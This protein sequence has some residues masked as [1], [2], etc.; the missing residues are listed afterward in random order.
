MSKEANGSKF[1]V[2]IQAQNQNGATTAV[3][4][5]SA[6]VPNAYLPQEE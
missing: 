2:D 5:G 4:K 3:G 6:I 1:T